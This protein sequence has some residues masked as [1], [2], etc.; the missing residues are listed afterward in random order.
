MKY[1]KYDKKIEPKN[2]KKSNP[3]SDQ[4]GLAPLGVVPNIYKVSIFP[5]LIKTSLIK[6]TEILGN[7]HSSKKS[8]R[9]MLG[10]LKN[11]NCY[12]FNEVICSSI[13][14]AFFKLGEITQ[15]N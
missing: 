3:K 10:F 2:P 1:V 4:I 15:S 9:K 12:Q 6:E 8:R 13:F 7:K 14:S 11:K 5:K